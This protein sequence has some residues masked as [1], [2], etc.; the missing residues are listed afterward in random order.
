[1]KFLILH[2][3]KTSSKGLN[4]FIAEFEKRIGRFAT[5]DIQAIEGLKGKGRSP[6]EV[7][8]VEAE[9][10]LAKLSDQDHVIRLDE[11]G[12]MM[13]SRAFATLISDQV[14]LSGQ[15]IVFLIGGAYG[16]DAR[17]HERADRVLGLSK[18]TFNHELALAVF[19]EQLYRAL[20]IIKGHPYHND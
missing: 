10:F 15:R 8:R 16:F 7:K 1:M 14:M 3:G 9:R 13:D 4:S 12:K 17:I 6:E 20:T 5:V 2:I 18:M 19:T 11:Q